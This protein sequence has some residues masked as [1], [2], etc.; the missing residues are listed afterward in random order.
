MKLI[1]TDGEA[2]EVALMELM[3]KLIVRF[4]DG[5]E[6][7]QSAMECVLEAGEEVA[8]EE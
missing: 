5:V 2:L 3:V 4:P 1:Q 8:D 7:I 6:R